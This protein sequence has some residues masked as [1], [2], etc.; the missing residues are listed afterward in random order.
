ME[1]GHSLLTKFQTA[2]LIGIR[3]EHVKIDKP[4]TGHLEAFVDVIEYLGADTFIVVNTDEYGEIRARASTSQNFKHKMKV[5]LNFEFSK[6][7]FF[8]NDGI[9]L[10]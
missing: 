4:G 7:H 6:L 10:T 2:K 8:D 3:P 5:S 9:K 1:Y